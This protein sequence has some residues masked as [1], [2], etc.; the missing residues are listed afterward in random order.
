MGRL[1]SSRR[2][3]CQASLPARSI[4][5]FETRAGSRSERNRPPP[6]RH[7]DCTATRT[8]PFDGLLGTE[9]GPYRLLGLL[10]VGG[11]SRIY[12]GR[13]VGLGHR[14]AVKLLAPH[15]VADA[16]SISRF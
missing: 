4:L 14:V 7:K 10:A 16:Q 11:M 13:H 15:L 3:S 8:V 2:R 12:I 1:F 6:G 9:I 5:G